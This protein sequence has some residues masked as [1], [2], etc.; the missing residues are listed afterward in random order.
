MQTDKQRNHIL[1]QSNSSQ[2]KKKKLIKSISEKFIEEYCVKI[3]TKHRPHKTKTS[4][5]TSISPSL[6]KNINNHSQLSNISTCSTSNNKK[7]K[8]TQRNRNKISTQLISANIQSNVGIRYSSSA[9]NLSKYNN[10]NNGRSSLGNTTTNIISPSQQKINVIKKQKKKFLSKISSDFLE[11]HEELNESTQQ[12]QGLKINKTKNKIKTQLL[13]KKRSISQHEYKT[14][15]SAMVMKNKNN[16]LKKDHNISRN[17]K[18]KDMLN[19]YDDSYN[20]LNN[21]IHQNEFHDKSPHDKK[22]IRLNVSMDNAKCLN[23]KVPNASINRSHYSE[24]Y[25]TNTNHNNLSL[26]GKTYKESSSYIVNIRNVDTPEELHFAFVNMKQQQKMVY[27]KIN[28]RIYG[29]DS[30]NVTNHG[31]STL[32]VKVSIKRNSNNISRYYDNNDNDNENNTIK[33]EEISFEDN[34]YYI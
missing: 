10:T 4:N 27:D 13:T 22:Q 14:E 18:T 24:H 9:L 12:K 5:K 21:N 1:K 33:K 20:T 29:N 19:V 3:S 32:S 23:R 16:V 28:N 15:S 34:H 25:Y 26:N 7:S 8:I 17:T 6:I 31:N 2:M 11:I 30:G